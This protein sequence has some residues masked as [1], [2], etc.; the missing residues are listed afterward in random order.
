MSQSK[1][2]STE[3]T[4]GAGFTYEDT[5]DAYYLAQLLGRERAAAQAG[6]VMSVA[7]QQQGQGNPMDDLVVEFDD[8]GT[9]RV[10]SLQIKRS[11]TVS[12]SDDDF[13]AI[14]AAVVQTQASEKFTKG[15][16][17]CGFVVEH[18]AD[19]P[20][21]TLRR[22]I[23]WAE[24]SSTGPE[25]E[26]RF[27]PGGTAA[28]AERDLRESLKS[29]IGAVSGDDEILFYRHFV[30]FRFDG[31]EENGARRADIINRL[32]EQVS[33]NEAGRDLLVFD[34]LCRIAREGAASGAKWTRDSLVAKLR[35]AVRLKVA[36]HLAGDV[37]RLNTYSLE[38]LRVV[39]ESVDDFHV[40]RAQLQDTVAK[41]LENH[42]VV[43]IGGLPGCGK[44]A[45]LKR[46]AQN[47]A[48]KGPI[49]F[50]KND[51]LQGTGWSQFAASLGL[52]VTGA[53]PLLAEIGSSGTPIL[54]IDG[55][56]RIRPDQQGIVV[57]LVSAVRREAVLSH[58]KILVSSRDQGLEAFRAWFPTA[59]YASSGIGDVIVPPFS[60]DEAEDL[61]VSKPHLR[62]VLFGSPAVK[63]IARRP[64]FAA[65]LA[66][67]VPEGIEPQTEVDLIA[68]WWA[69]AGHD[70]AADTVPQ[71]QRALIDIAEKGV[72]NLGKG[73]PARDLRDA[74]MAHIAALKNDHIVRD[75][76]QGASL[77][78]THDIFFEWAFFRLLIDLGDE[79]TNALIAAGEPPL[80]GRVV[81]LLA[82]GALMEE[83]Q[84]S[85][86]YRSLV[87]KNMRRQW[88]REWLTAPP[89]TPAFDGAAAEFAALLKTDSFALFEKVLVWFQAQHTIPSPLILGNITSPVEG[90]DNLSVADMLGWPSDFGAWG[91][92]IDW[93]IREVDS[94]PVRLIPRILE[95]FDVWQNVGA[96]LQNPRSAAI[97]QLA[98]S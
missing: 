79:W 15:A 87:G 30:A 75:E 71:R 96:E 50:L 80:L 95:V 56:D 67:S 98:D 84:W 32:Q 97:L 74:T 25:F 46:F 31:L 76:R 33:G 58:W 89:F 44:S 88:Q 36:P 38:A 39:S 28:R 27:A 22:L 6:V 5:V 23:A 48:T 52:S 85:N 63:D 94:V 93:I 26:A 64:F 10:L 13:S 8:A 41:Q 57:D 3:L 78:F 69:R 62:K 11:I 51:R 86:G 61:A 72:R 73:I 42:R 54:F 1:P 35:G 19:A 49:L 53:E 83:G 68:A 17:K 70:A 91:R 9:K 66:R 81:G 7:V 24:E 16:D 90:L 92:L 12:T 18:V 2:A 82:Q 60:D 20:L 65:V 29:A 37:D 4:G 77:A 40:E 34:R 55:I 21:R 47:A 45:V 59:M 14:I 43:T